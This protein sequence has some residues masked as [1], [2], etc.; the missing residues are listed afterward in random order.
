[1]YT[2]TIQCLIIAQILGDVISGMSANFE[3]VPGKGLQCSVQGVEYSEQA[4]MTSEITRHIYY[5]PSTSLMSTGDQTG[6]APR[7]YK[8]R[9]GSLSLVASSL[10]LHCEQVL[11]G[12]RDWMQTN[13]LVVTDEVEVDVQTFEQQG[14]TVVLCAVDG[15]PLL[16]RMGQGAWSIR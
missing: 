1:M 13:G 2:V 8:V 6:Q 14:Q 4:P 10:W 5:T 12:N 9:G 16:R 3:A 15:E 7:V 11:I